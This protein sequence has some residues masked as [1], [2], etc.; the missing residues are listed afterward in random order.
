M[1]L[2]FLYKKKY[3]LVFILLMWQMNNYAQMR[4]CTSSSLPPNNCND[5]C[6]YCDIDG[7]KGRNNTI[8]GS[9]PVTFCTPTTDNAQ[10]IAFVA[11]THYL[12]AGGC[13]T[14]FIKRGGL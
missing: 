13:G 5:A 9:L 6:V 1:W 12:T 7:L 4:L 11:G 8:R 2:Q 14:N 10:W 3:L